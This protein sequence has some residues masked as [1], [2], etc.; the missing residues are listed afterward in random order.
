MERKQKLIKKEFS[1]SI[2]GINQGPPMAGP[3]RM[4]PPSA[5]KMSSEII[6]AKDADGDGVLSVEE[7]TL[8]EDKFGVLD[9]NS[10]GSISEDELVIKLT[11]KLEAM[12]EKMDAGQMRPKGPPPSDGPPPAGPPPEE[13][14]DETDELTELERL[15]EM[16]NGVGAIM[17]DSIQSGADMYTMI[18]EEL[19]M[20]NEEQSDFFQMY[21][22]NGM[23]ILA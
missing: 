10:D 1:M 16:M 4:K 11:E 5:A 20:S 17:T 9:T 13:A 23:D 15:L 21:Q 18:L 8:S 7:S 2:D 6:S 3:P 22:N 19:G 14:T 12:K